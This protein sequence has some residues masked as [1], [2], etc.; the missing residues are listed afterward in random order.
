[1]QTLI[2]V[3]AISSFAVSSAV[4]GSGVY[5]YFNKDALMQQVIGGS[6]TALMEGLVESP[7]DLLP[8]PLQAPTEAPQALPVNPFSPF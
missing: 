1:M 7:S 4:V 6:T 5:I 8:T 3:L 2:N